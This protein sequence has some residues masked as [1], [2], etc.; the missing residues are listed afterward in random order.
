MPGKNGFQFLTTLVAHNFKIVFITAYNEYAIQT[1]KLNALDYILK[2]VNIDELQSTVEKIKCSLSSPL[3]AEQ[4]Q[5]LLKHLLQ[6]VNIKTPP[7]KIS[8]LNWEE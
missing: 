5:L 8:C 4:N 3:A 1:I 7:K 6:T 2:P